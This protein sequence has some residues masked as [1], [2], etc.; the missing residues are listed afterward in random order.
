MFNKDYDYCA[1]S[2]WEISRRKR[3]EPYA[4]FYNSK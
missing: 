3:I 4:L 2:A 1:K